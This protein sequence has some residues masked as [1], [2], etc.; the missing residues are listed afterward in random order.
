MKAGESWGLWPWPGMT[1]R[2][3]WSSRSRTSQIASNA[4]LWAPETTSVGSRSDG[5]LGERDLRLPRPALAHQRLDTLL[6][7]GREG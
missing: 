5:E 4:R 7:P 1:T 6:E 3:A 2:S